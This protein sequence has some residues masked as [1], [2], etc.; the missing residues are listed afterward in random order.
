MSNTRAIRRRIKSVESTSKITKA[1]EMVSA[2]KLRK[3]QS[4]IEAARP[5]A[6]TMI[7]FTSDLSK[8]SGVGD[9]PLLEEREQI[10]NVCVVA[11]TADRGQCGTFN[12]N[13]LKRCEGIIRRERQA[14]RNVQ[15]VVI[16]KKGYT[17]FNFRQVAMLE[18]YRDVMDAPDYASA[19]RIADFLIELF[20]GGGTDEVILVYN[21]FKSIMEQ[22]VTEQVLLPIPK[23]DVEQDKIEGKFSIDY[24]F[25]PSAEAL[26]ESIL[27]AYVETSVFRT[28]LESSA[29]E[30]GARMTAMKMASDNAGEII[31]TLVLLLNK[32]RQAQITQEISEIV[33]GVESMKYSKS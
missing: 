17:Y 28:L 1:M 33:G 5:Y 19:K 25:E 10:E 2:S 30:H 4:A 12:T 11:I 23:G 22:I 20:S 29:G 13:V 26:F 6:E 9:F 31:S 3:A 16:G 14:G 32:S 8:V 15:L 24:T 27:P 7:E 21:A 18:S